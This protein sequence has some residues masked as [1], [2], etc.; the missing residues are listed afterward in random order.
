M[1][2][3]GSDEPAPETV[4]PPRAPEPVEATA[5]GLPGRRGVLAAAVVAA[6]VALVLVGQWLTA[7]SGHRPAPQPVAATWPTAGSASPPT[8]LG[9][10]P[11]PGTVPPPAPAS[12]V[13]GSPTAGPTG[14]AP[15]A[16]EATFCSTARADLLSIGSEGLATLKSLATQAGDVSPRARAFV[17]SVTARVTELRQA[18][19]TELTEALST[20]ASAWSGLSA[21][22]D[23]SGY[24]RASLVGLAIK[25]LTGPGVAV[26]WDVLTGWAAHNCGAVPGPGPDGVVP[27]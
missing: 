14:R 22:L 11:W 6:V 21:A 18:A 5:R 20:L 12:A 27:G 26:S 15:R 9:D 4:D 10:R 23:R 19:P 8:P 17:R 24:D 7:P 3:F 2:S 13:S 25:Y 1:A 16:A